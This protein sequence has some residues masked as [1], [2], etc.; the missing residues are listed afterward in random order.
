LKPGD[1]IRFEMVTLD[2]AH[3]ALRAQRDKLE[4]VKGKVIRDAP[5]RP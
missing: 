3:A 1:E 5:G 2:Q 4:A